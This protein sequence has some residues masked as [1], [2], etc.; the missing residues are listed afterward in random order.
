VPIKKIVS[1]IQTAYK[2][3]SPSLNNLHAKTTGI[4]LSLPNG[5]KID[6]LAFAAIENFFEKT[7]SLNSAEA[8]KINELDLKIILKDFGM[9]KIPDT[10][11]DVASKGYDN[12]KRRL[13]DLPKI[14]QKIF[15]NQVAAAELKS[16]ELLFNASGLKK[17]DIPGRRFPQSHRRFKISPLI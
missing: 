14:A 4:Y 1:K 3:V 11:L 9:S 8:G 17:N 10:V 2:E 15:V 7:N 13:F 5:T 16:D 6:L 12:L